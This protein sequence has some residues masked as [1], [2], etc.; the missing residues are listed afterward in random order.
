MSSRAASDGISGVGLDRVVDDPIA[1]AVAG[2]TALLVAFAV[3]TATSWPIAALAGGAAYATACL[4]LADRPSDAAA[5]TRPWPIARALKR[6]GYA[7]AIVYAAVFLASQTSDAPKAFFCASA[8][9]WSPAIFAVGVY[10]L[11]VLS[12]LGRR[13]N[14]SGLVHVVWVGIAWIAPWYGFFN[15]ATVT[16]AGLALACEDRS[17]SDYAMLAVF[18]SAAS[19]AGTF[20]GRWLADGLPIRQ[21]N[22]Y[23]DL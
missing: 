22:P 14:K 7:F 16:G 8:V 10:V 18:G 5:R 19:I 2:A 4:F 11:A 21:I 20:I 9:P 23:Q 12:E 15:V 1:A 17:A 3:S 6:H 13:Q